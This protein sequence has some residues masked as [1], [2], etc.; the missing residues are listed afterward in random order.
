MKN[1]EIAILD[2]GI[3]DMP[4][5]ESNVSVIHLSLGTLLYRDYIYIKNVVEKLIQ[6]NIV[7]VAAFHNETLAKGAR[8]QLS[9]IMVQENQRLRNCLQECI[10]RKRERYI[11][12]NWKF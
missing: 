6:N 12:T 1:L 8:R 5:L 10:F 4:H 11:W 9:E 3:S 7:I 2:T